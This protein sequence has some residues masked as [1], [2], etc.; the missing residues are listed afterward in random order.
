MPKALI[1]EDDRTA[2]RALC[3]WIERRGFTATDVDNAAKARKALAGDR[4]DVVLLDVHLPDASGIDLLLELPKDTRPQ[5]VLMSGDASIGSAFGS[6][7]LDELHFL[8]KPIEPKELADLLQTVRRRCRRD[9]EDAEKATARIL[10]ESAAIL[11]LRKLIAKV[12]PTELSV[13]VEGESG[14]GKELIAQAVHANSPRSGGPFVAIN[15]GAIPENL[16]DSELF[17]HEKGSFT[18]A[19]KAREGVFERASGGTLFLDEVAEMPVELQVRLLRVL[20][21]GK[22]VRVGASAERDVDVRIVAA[23]NRSFEQAI[24]EGT[25]REDLFH[26]LC[27]FP[28]V[29]PPLRERGDDVQVLANS[30]LAE[31][32]QRPLRLD[33]QAGLVVGSYRWP[34]NVRQLRN[35]MQRAAVLAEGDH[36]GA[37]TLPEQVLSSIDLASL[38]SD[39]GE[40]EAPTTPSAHPDGADEAAASPPLAAEPNASDPNAIELSLGTTIAEAERRLIEATLD[41]QGG[42]KKA[43]AEVLGVSLRTL[44]NR[45]N[46]YD[47][48]PDEAS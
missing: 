27:V 18:G 24:Q 13:Y 17:G 44:Y 33:A 8:K 12:A 22:V 25:L 20:E 4:F 48:G 21:T 28:I 32:A 23:T 29:S 43:T 15:C 10:G 5:A 1:V 39:H 36:V 30:F 19:D 42:N 26:R 46:T 14:T 16:I 7:P 45:L 35:A 3:E 31:F 2:R 38:P 9:A 40:P 34:G 6:L 47:E 41:Q 37:S 11:R